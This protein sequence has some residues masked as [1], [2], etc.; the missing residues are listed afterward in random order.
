LPPQAHLEHEVREKAARE[1][2]HMS[3][4]AD[5]RAHGGMSIDSF[6]RLSFF[7]IAQ[8][9]FDKTCSL[10]TPLSR[11]ARSTANNRQGDTYGGGRAL[12]LSD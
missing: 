12:R 10:G 5:L 8:V 7:L 4:V 9:G 11:V 3:V 6:N 2:K 1:G